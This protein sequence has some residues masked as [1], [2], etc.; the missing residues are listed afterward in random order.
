MFI[1]VVQTARMRIVLG[2][3]G[4]TR[5]LRLTA[6]S[7]TRN[8]LSP[9]AECG[10]EIVLLGHFNLPALIDNPRSGENAIPVDTREHE[11]LPFDSVMLEPQQS[12]A[13]I[14]EFA[15][16]SAFPDAFCDG[17]RSVQNLCQQ[18][19]S[20]RRL[21]TMIEP[22]GLHTAD[23]VLFLRPDLLY[24]EPLDFARDIEPVAA[25]CF[26]IIVPAW[27]GW[28]GVNDRFAICSPRAAEIYANRIRHFISA[29]LSLN[30]IHSETFLQSVLAEAGL[31]IGFTPLQAMRIRANGRQAAND[32][33]FIAR[34]RPD[35]LPSP[36]V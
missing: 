36:A 11:A 4:I 10:G 7:I 35:L 8:I 23:L 24:P 3:F 13:V 33:A 17:Y 27:Q 25:G 2:F 15:V 1:V 26:D 6:G 16:A 19:H 29:C 18:L 12:E 34:H 30:G 31:R 28:G 5:S 32:L 20:L 9:L 14:D 21:W 22:L